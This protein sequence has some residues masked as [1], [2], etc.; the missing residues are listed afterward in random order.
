ME[1]LIHAWEGFD[2]SLL[3]LKREEREQSQEVQT[4]FINWHWPTADS[5]QANGPSQS[6]SYKELHS[7]N[8]PSEQGVAPSFEPQKASQPC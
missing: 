6:Y 2:P 3:A 7:A 8:S 4:T 5:Q 1:G